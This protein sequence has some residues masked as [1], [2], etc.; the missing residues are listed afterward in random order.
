MAIF[1]QTETIKYF[2]CLFYDDFYFFRY[3]WFTVF[4]QFS[5]AQQVDPVTHTYIHSFSHTILYHSP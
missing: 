4:C 2:V 3:S 1:K 5:T